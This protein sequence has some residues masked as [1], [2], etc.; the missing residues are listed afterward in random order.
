MLAHLGRLSPS[1]EL[2]KEAIWGMLAK[3]L[4]GLG[5]RLGGWG[6]KALAKAAP[7]AG[8][9]GVVAGKGLKGMAPASGQLTAGAAPAAPGMFSKAWGAFNQY[10]MPAMSGANILSGQGS[11]LDAVGLAGAL[12]GRVGGV[13][14]QAYLPL[15]L[16]QNFFGGS[17]GSAT[18]GPAGAAGTGMAGA[19]PQVSSPF[20]GYSPKNTSEAWKM[21]MTPQASARNPERCLAFEAGVE[22][23]AKD[24]GFDDEDVKAMYALIKSADEGFFK[25]LGRQSAEDAPPG[26]NWWN[27]FSWDGKDQAQAAGWA[28]ASKVPGGTLAALG[29]EGV[30]R[31]AGAGMGAWGDFQQGRE[32]VAL[33]KQRREGLL[34]HGIDPDKVMGEAKSDRAQNAGAAQRSTSE[35]A[36]RK[37]Y[38]NLMADGSVPSDIAIRRSLAAGGIHRRSP[39][40]DKLRKEWTPPAAAGEQAAP[41]TMQPRWTPQSTAPIFGQSVK[42]LTAAAQGTP[43]LGLNPPVPGPGVSYKPPPKAPMPSPGNPDSPD[44]EPALPMGA[45]PGAQ[46]L[47]LSKGTGA[48]W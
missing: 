9:A 17:K 19:L 5:T 21:Y 2:H 44:A 1:G 48:I 41:A 28:L 37:M 26:G 8:Q 14:G 34:R 46:A 47:K 24:A 42:S 10:A 30:S 23:F 12:P 45:P 20:Q 38:S 32:A 33:N 35:D 27:P 40:A 36:V 39:L 43:S 3:G 15:M 29:A 7:A 13:A 31:L 25:N 11:A 6:L 22:R 4:M 18:S 16:A